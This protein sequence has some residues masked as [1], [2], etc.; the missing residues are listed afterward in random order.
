MRMPRSELWQRA[1]SSAAVAGLPPIA[2][3]SPRSMAALS[4]PVCWWALIVCRNN[5]GDGGVSDSGMEACL[6][7]DDGGAGGAGELGAT[8]ASPDSTADYNLV[9]GGCKFAAVELNDISGARVPDDLNRRAGAKGDVA[10]RR[11][12]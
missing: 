6:F 4:A 3:K 11:W 7:M 12:H 2:V 1:A 5:C 8:S 9:A 10:I